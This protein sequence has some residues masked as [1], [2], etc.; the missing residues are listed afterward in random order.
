MSNAI[1]FWVAADEQA[2]AVNLDTF[3]V[4]VVGWYRVHTF[5]DTGSNR[6]YVYKSEG[7]APGYQPVVIRVRGVSSNV[8]Y[9]TYNTWNDDA[10][11]GTGLQP[12]TT[13]S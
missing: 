3:L 1:R 2:Y 7:E 5:S 12:T 8:Q 11:T 10:G 13:L 4:N 9:D 6:D